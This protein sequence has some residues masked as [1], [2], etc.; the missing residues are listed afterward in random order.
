MPRDASW[1]LESF[2]RSKPRDVEFLY[3]VYVDYDDEAAVVEVPSVEARAAVYFGLR[4]DVVGQQ[5]FEEDVPVFV[6]YALARYAVHHPE[7]EHGRRVFERRRYHVVVAD[8]PALVVEH[9]VAEAFHAVG[10]GVAEVLR[11]YLGRQLVEAHS[12]EADAYAA[13][14]VRVMYAAEA[15]V[16]EDGAAPEQ[17]PQR[18]EHVLDAVAVDGEAQKFVVYLFGIDEPSGLPVYDGGYHG[19]Y[20]VA[21]GVFF[22]DRDYREAEQ[23]RGGE[24][25]ARDFVYEAAR[26]HAE[27]GGVFFMQLIY[28]LGQQPFVVLHGEGGGEHQL[29]ASQPRGAVG[30]VHNCDR[31]YFPAEAVSSRE[32]LYAGK[33]RHLKQVFHCYDVFIHG[34]SLP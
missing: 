25:V 27:A 16:Y 10:D 8:R 33:R 29:F 13:R 5:V 20:Y 7:R 18:G 31:G 23:V 28:E 34:T 2:S 6:L 19:V 24:R 15:H 26:L 32:K 14:A 12:R 1:S 17:R 4:L 30:R 22:R 3:V 11:Q 9:D 21:E